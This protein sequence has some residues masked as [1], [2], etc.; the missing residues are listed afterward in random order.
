MVPITR[1]CKIIPTE[2][3]PGKPDDLSGRKSRSS[4]SSVDSSTR[5]V[6]VVNVTAA[7]VAVDANSPL[8][9]QNLTFDIRVTAIQKGLSGSTAMATS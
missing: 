2:Q 9:G 8:A 5:V 3:V 1:P 7:G 4:R 6:Y